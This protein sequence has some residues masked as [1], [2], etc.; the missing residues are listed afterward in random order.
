MDDKLRELLDA[1]V[2]KIAE[3]GKKS[4]RSKLQKIIVVTVLAVVIGIAVHIGLKE[5]AYRKA[6]TLADEGNYTEAIT[7]FENLKSYRSSKENAESVT[8]ANNFMKSAVSHAQSEQ[9]SKELSAYKTVFP[10]INFD[11]SFDWRTETFIIQISSD[12]LSKSDMEVTD[13]LTSAILP[14]FVALCHDIDKNSQSIQTACKVSGGYSVDCSIECIG[15]DGELLYSSLNGEEKTSCIDITAAEETM[16]GQSYQEMV[17]AVDTENYAQ[18]CS[19]WDTLNANG[20]Y[21]LSYKDISDYYYYAKVMSAY[22]SSE[23]VSLSQFKSDLKNISEDFKNTKDIK[24]K[25]TEITETAGSVM[26]G[27]YHKD[28]CEF[29][30]ENGNLAWKFVSGSEKGSNLSAKVDDYFVKDGKISQA[31]AVEVE[32]DGQGGITVSKADSGVKVTFDNSDDEAKYGGSYLPGSASVEVKATKTSN[33]S[34]TS[35]TTKNG[36]IYGTSKNPP[37]NAVP[38]TDSAIQ[39]T[40]KSNVYNETDWDYQYF[41]TFSNGKF[42]REHYNYIYEEYIQHNYDNRE[43]VDIG[44]YY[45][46]GANIV[47]TYQNHSLWYNGVVSGQKTEVWPVSYVHSGGIRFQNKVGGCFSYYRYE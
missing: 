13:E 29:K 26:N 8:H 37:A 40:W 15:T 34:S 24:D 39:G 19:I 31:H 47:V 20:Y 32:T 33:A 28:F 5:S 3:E 12:N 10:D 1:D 2:S 30:I 44:S 46:D 4:N 41:I 16:Y 27:T 35:I 43:S 18:C 21:R 45:I 11:T 7:A 25:I 36:A 6:L 42:T 38:L 14:S 23:A 17:T 22:T 9:L